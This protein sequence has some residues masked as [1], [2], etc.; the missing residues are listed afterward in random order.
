MEMDG[1]EEGADS[2]RKRRV[3]EA[4]EDEGG[5]REEVVEG[6]GEV[7][8]VGAATASDVSWKSRTR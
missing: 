5:R 3:G 6:A 2:Q 1:E 7:E 4:G 8:V